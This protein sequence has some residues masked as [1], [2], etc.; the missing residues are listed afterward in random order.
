MGVEMH[1]AER[2]AHPLRQRSQQRQGHAVI[3][4][5]GHQ[6][7]DPGGL[8]LDAGEALPDVAQRHGEIAEIG[9]IALGRLLPALG[10]GAV[11]QHGA[12]ATDR[13]RTEAGARPVGGADIEGN[14][15]DGDAGHLARR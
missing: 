3:A 2:P 1:E 11:H 7:V 9:E 4:A 5:E 6:V 13:R 14:A 12:G 10:V 8:T 15:R